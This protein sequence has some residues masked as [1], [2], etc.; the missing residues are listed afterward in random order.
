MMRVKSAGEVRKASVQTT[1]QMWQSL[2]KPHDRVLLEWNQFYKRSHK[3][4]SEG[5]RAKPEVQW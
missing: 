1:K 5:P 4:R 3:L 2:F